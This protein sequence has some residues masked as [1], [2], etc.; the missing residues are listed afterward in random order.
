MLVCLQTVGEISGDIQLTN[1]ISKLVL[2]TLKFTELRLLWSRSSYATVDLF[3]VSKQPAR[4]ST[5]L[6]LCHG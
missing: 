3:K 1:I 5:L 2:L 4:Q 6:S